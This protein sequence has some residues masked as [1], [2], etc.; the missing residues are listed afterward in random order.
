MAPNPP[1]KGLKSQ[2]KG[3]SS[4]AEVALRVKDCGRNDRVA[5]EMVVVDLGDWRAL[6]LPT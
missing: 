3:L 6:L 1:Y 5:V 2:V 4:S